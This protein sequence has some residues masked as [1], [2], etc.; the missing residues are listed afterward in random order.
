MNAIL[1]T[2]ANGL[3]GS[4]LAPML[5]RSG[6]DVK[7]HARAVSGDYQADLTNREDTFAMLSQV[8]PTAIINLA[9]LTNVDLC[10]AEPNL[11][12]LANVR[13]VES[14]AY[15]IKKTRA[16]CHLVHVSTDQIFDGEQLHDEEHVVLK[17]YY[18]FSKYAGELIA[19]SVSSTIL[20][21]NFFGKSRCE[22]RQSLT[23]WIFDSVSSGKKI[24][25]FEDVYFS[26]LSMNTLGKI[27]EMVLQKKAF[28]TFNVGS[29]DGMSKAAFAFDFAA[30]AGLSLEGMTPIS[31]NQATFLKTYRP[32]NMCMNC[33]KFEATLKMQLP[34]L[35]DEIREAAREYHD[36]T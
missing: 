36:A 34:T 7:T 35:K 30:K 17:N 25:V 4:T 9:G 20:R 26:P 3:L 32:K 5:R 22:K 33:A 18:A 16:N 15:W 8:Q 14:L 27:I 13:T 19:N 23:D 21:T 31:V 6:F 2:G 29:R 1:V 10:E 11:A 28:G 24:Q 12:F